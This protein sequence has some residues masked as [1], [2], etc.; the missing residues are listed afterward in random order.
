MATAGELLAI[1]WNRKRGIF[2]CRF[3]ADGAITAPTIIYLP[4]DW[5]G[6]GTK[7]TP[8]LRFEH[9]H[10]EQ[11]LLVFNDGF[12]GEVEVRVKANS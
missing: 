12:G 5:F 10:E 2:R 9:R 3:K 1:T 11:R 7:V 4:A 8:P 6:P